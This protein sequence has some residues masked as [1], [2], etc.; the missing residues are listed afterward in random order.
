MTSFM[1]GPYYEQHFKLILR[2]VFS[3]LFT[4]IALHTKT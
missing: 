4:F 3:E 1:D 2:S